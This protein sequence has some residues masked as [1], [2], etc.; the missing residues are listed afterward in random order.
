MHLLFLRVSS[1]RRRWLLKDHAGSFQ[2][3]Q[4][5]LRRFTQLPVGSDELA[6]DAADV[7]LERGVAREETFAEGALEGL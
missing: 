1:Y 7:V 6:V 3:E 4:L 5:L 2:K